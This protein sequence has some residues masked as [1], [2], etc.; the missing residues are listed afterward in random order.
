MAKLAAI[1]QIGSLGD[2]ILSVPVLRSLRELLPDCSEYLLVS[3]FDSH[4]KVMPSHVFEM[5]WEPKY[6][7]DY[8]GAGDWLQRIGSGASTLSRLRYFRPH[9]CIYLMP[10]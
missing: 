3:R 5:V 2:S 1:F 4:M 10:S 9:Y 8:R 7:I 6:R